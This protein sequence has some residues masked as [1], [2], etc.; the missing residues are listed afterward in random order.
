[1]N[2]GEVQGKGRRQKWVLIIVFVSTV[3]LNLA[4]LPISI[5][6]G[7]MATDAPGSGFPEFTFGFSFVQAIPLIVFCIVISVMIVF[8]RRSKNVAFV[9]VFINYL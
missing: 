6:I 9:M 8:I 5:F 7:G 3:V 1:M 4:V 2:D